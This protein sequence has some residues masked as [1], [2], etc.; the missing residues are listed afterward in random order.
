MISSILYAISPEVEVASIFESSDVIPESVW[1]K[2]E[3]GSRG[4]VHDKFGCSLYLSENEDWPA[5]LKDMLR[6]MDLHS[7]LLRALR[8]QGAALSVSIG[9]T[10]GS[11]HHYTRTLRFPPTALKRFSDE[12]IEIEISAYPCSDD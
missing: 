4:R 11:D 5:N 8:D 2:G 3:R 9:T 10:V 12:E 7:P 1:A 6:F